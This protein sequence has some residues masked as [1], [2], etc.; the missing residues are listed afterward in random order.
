MA[1]AGEVEDYKVTIIS[2]VTVKFGSEIETEK[3]YKPEDLGIIYNYNSEE[4]GMPNVAI[5]GDK[6]GNIS[7][8]EIIEHKITIL[9]KTNSVQRNL[10][11][12]YNSNIAGEFVELV[13]EKVGKGEVQV[14]QK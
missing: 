3:D 2:G 10:W 12:I 1:T 13:E 9:N 5:Y 14:S 6:D 4:N 8:K 11:L 7:P